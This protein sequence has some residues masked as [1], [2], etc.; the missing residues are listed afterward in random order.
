MIGVAAVE[1]TGQHIFMQLVH[2][3]V[4]GSQVWY[5]AV[6]GILKTQIMFLHRLRED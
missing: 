4:S 1:G 5:A 6:M 3:I 2:Q